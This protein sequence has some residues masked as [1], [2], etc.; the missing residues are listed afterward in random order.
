MSNG[1]NRHEHKLP[2]AN[3][4]RDQINEVLARYDI[5]SDVYDSDVLIDALCVSAVD[6]IS[7]DI[8]PVIEK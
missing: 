4:L 8:C 6:K 7:T 2:L 1:V 5:P 3:W